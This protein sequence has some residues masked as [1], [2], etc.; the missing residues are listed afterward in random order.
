M[1]EKNCDPL[2]LWNSYEDC[3]WKRQAKHQQLTVLVA[4]NGSLSLIADTFLQFCDILIRFFLH[5]KFFD[6][7]LFMCKNN[8]GLTTHH[9]LDY[10]ISKSCRSVFIVKNLINSQFYRGQ[11]SLDGIFRWVF[12]WKSW[13]FRSFSEGEFFVF[14]PC[15]YTNLFCKCSSFSLNWGQ[16]VLWSP[17]Q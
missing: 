16:N 15:L 11:S 5:A 4:R 7:V 17:L 8:G 1:G 14:E 6:F 12:S 10:R 9:I 3:R 2:H 13:A